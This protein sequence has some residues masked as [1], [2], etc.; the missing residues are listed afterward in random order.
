MKW[1]GCSQMM[2]DTHTYTHAHT[3]THT[4]ALTH[5]H[6][7]AHTH[8]PTYARTHAQYFMSSDSMEY[9]NILEFASN[10]LMTACMSFWWAI[11]ISRI[12]GFDVS[13]RHNV[14][15]NLEA[16]VSGRRF[17]RVWMCVRVG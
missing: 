3:H 16:R 1:V 17:G 13:L 10:G 9:W 7:H 12:D 6:M 14:Y 8:T 5:S 15:A 11:K 2:M 4:H